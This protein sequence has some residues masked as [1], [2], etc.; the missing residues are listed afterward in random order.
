[1]SLQTVRTVNRWIIRHGTAFQSPGAVE[2]YAALV[3]YDNGHTCGYMMKTRGALLDARHGL[4]TTDKQ[5]AAMFYESFDTEA[6]ALAAALKR[7]PHYD[8]E[9]NTRIR[10]RVW[11]VRQYESTAIAI[12]RVAAEIGCTD[13]RVRAIASGSSKAKKHE[14]EAVQ[15]ARHTCGG[16]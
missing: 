10:E 9:Y 2:E 5:L 14:A 15:P 16:Y 11:I 7:Y 4:A 3:R 12:D 8:N 1:M 6:E 13:D